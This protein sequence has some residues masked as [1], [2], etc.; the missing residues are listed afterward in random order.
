M[1]LHQQNISVTSMSVVYGFSRTNYTIL[2]QK[3]N[4]TIYKWYTLYIYLTRQKWCAIYYYCLKLWI[5]GQANDI[6][7]CIM[8]I[9]FVYGFVVS[10][11]NSTRILKCPFLLSMDFHQSKIVHAIL[12]FCL[13][14]DFTPNKI[15]QSLPCPLT[16][17]RIIV[18]LFHDCYNSIL[19]KI[20]APAPLVMIITIFM[21]I[22]VIFLVS[23]PIANL[24][25]AKINVHRSWF[26]ND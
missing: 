5:W 15:Y 26:M 3:K 17:T 9:C 2:H 12:L 7:I 23:F 10:V 22:N 25:T 18:M 14:M 13:S 4:L 6:Y 20:S 24:W 1:I 11:K 8:S 16:C 21:I 19:Y